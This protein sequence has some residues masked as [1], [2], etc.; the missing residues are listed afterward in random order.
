MNGEKVRSGESQDSAAPETSKHVQVVRAVGTNS[1]VK[2]DDPLKKVVVAFWIRLH[3][4][5]RVNMAAGPGVVVL[6]ANVAD[7]ERR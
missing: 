7:A 4:R 5:S 6:S 3:Q 2:R 1:G